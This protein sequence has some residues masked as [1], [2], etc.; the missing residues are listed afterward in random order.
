MLS[1]SVAIIG[2]L[3]ALT[4]GFIDA[5]AGGGGLIMV[6]A[7]LI[8]GIPP[9]LALGTNKVSASMG[10]FIAVCTFAKSRLVIWRLALSGMAFML[11][12]SW[13]GTLL[14][15]QLSSAYLGKI[16]VALLPFA[17]LVTILPKKE[18]LNQQPV[19]SGTRYWL[20]M[21]LIFLSIG[22]YDGFF[23]PGTGSFL[24]L[25]LHWILSVGLIKASATAKVLNLCSNLG[26]A[27]SFI[28]HGSVHWPLA[29]L[30]TVCC[31]LGNWLG[32]RM[33]IRIGERAVRRFLLVSLG[34]LLIT[35]VY[36]YF[37]VSKP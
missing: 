29:T 35:L 11:I 37:F 33:A 12:G 6:P 25:A 28:W 15:F 13:L 8:S 3:A 17:M 16:M 10:T 2:G 32:S 27:V 34:L 4:G 9:H 31:M 5:I 22:A 19:L 7:L 18:R 20:L 21:P 36:Q 26:A 1:L 30:M 14:T 24:I 23:G